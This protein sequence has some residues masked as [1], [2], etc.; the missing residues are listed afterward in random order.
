MK[1]ES[2]FSFLQTALLHLKHLNSSPYEQPW[3]TLQTS[4]TNNIRGRSLQ[5]IPNTKQNYSSPT[6]PIISPCQH[7]NNATTTPIDRYL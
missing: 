6:F 3:D 1:S 2:S 7:S 5:T 4:L